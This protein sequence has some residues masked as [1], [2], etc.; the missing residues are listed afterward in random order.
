MI[1]K[2]DYSWLIL[3]ASLGEFH[4]IVPELVHLAEK[5]NHKLF[6]TFV[7]AGIE[8]K[9]YSNPLYK[10]L[11][12]K[13]F[14]VIERRNI[15]LFALQNRNKINYLFRDIS[16]IER[17]SVIRSLKI[18]L[19]KARLILFPHAFAFYVSKLYSNQEDITP[20]KHNIY[21]NCANAVLTYTK[22]DKQFFGQRFDERFTT[23]FLPRGLNEQW[24][25]VVK[26]A[27]GETPIEKFEKKH[28]KRI[29]LTIRHPHKIY[30]S[31]EDYYELLEEVINS[32][33]NIGYELFIKPHPRQNFEELENF[34][35][36]NNVAMWIND[37]Y[38][39]ALY[40]NYVIT[41]WSSASID[42]AAFKIPTIEHFRYRKFHTQLIKEN[43][44]LY[45]IYVKM[46]LS[47]PSTNAEELAVALDSAIS[48]PK[49][50]GS[51]QR[52]NLLQSYDANYLDLNSINYRSTKEHSFLSKIAHI[53]RLSYYAI[54]NR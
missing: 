38:T 43:G 39:S 32:V 42:F 2:N 27:V 15:L 31:T 51:R 19:P 24:L 46:G 9:F 20:P 34:C 30:L 3:K 48:N 54:N 33:K 23:I 11:A 17:F 18:I 10:T 28:P 26:K 40:F 37:T 8:K 16:T 41:F 4:V 25:E 36:A 44:H 53:G 13:Y 6:I 45:S 49:E 5:Q 52:S 1:E 22:E 35:K 21:E 7:S 29:L 14:T 47:L 12:E 50:I